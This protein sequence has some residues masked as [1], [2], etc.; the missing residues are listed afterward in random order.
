MTDELTPSDDEQQPPAHA[1]HRGDPVP[2]GSL[3]DEP[4]ATQPPSGAE[5]WGMPTPADGENPDVPLDDE[6]S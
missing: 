5:P 4:D 2:D 1:R 3:P 6:R